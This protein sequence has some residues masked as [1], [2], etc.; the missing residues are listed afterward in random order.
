MK[1]ISFLTTALLSIIIGAAMFFM[2]L[3]SLNGFTGKQAEPGL[4]LFVV[5]VLLASLGA[6]V[7]SFLSAKYLA[8][9]K[10]LNRWWAALTAIAGFVIIGVI[11]NAIGFFAAVFLTSAMR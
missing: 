1:I 5:W 10:S 6:G 9:K 7:L 3:L 8:E 2:L 4:M 11:I